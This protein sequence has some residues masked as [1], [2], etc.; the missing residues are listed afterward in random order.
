MFIAGSALTVMVAAIALWFTVLKP[1]PGTDAGASAMEDASFATHF[2]I[3]APGNGEIT[4][5]GVIFLL[6]G[7]HSLKLTGVQL[8]D[9]RMPSALHLLSAGVLPL[10]SGLTQA[11]GIRPGLPSTLGFDGSVSPLSAWAPSRSPGTDYDL[12]LGLKVPSGTGPFTVTGVR[13][14]Y[15]LGSATYSLLLR[16]DLTVC[17]TADP[18]CG[19][20]GTADAAGK[21]PSLLKHTGGCSSD[22]TSWASGKPARA[23]LATNVHSPYWEGSGGNIT[24]ST[25]RAATFTMVSSSNYETTVTATAQSRFPFVTATVVASAKATYGISLTRSVETTSTWQYTLTV[26]PNAPT[27]RATVYVYGWVLPVTTETTALNCGTSYAYGTVYAPA[28]ST[29]PG[30]D[31]CIAV[32]PYPGVADL[33]PTCH[34]G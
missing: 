2:A 3:G 11:V 10:T 26:S 31:Y 33:G 4:D 13:L 32:E 7:A 1:S 14:A 22:T 20:F 5:G 19:E 8:L 27:E 34:S 17:A 6:T 29:N 25:T 30:N 16:H 12:I 15:R 24:L 28:A 18:S 9:R 21:S 23:W